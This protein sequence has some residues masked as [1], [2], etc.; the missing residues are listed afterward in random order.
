MRLTPE[1]TDLL[2]GCPCAKCGARALKV[3][4]KFHTVEADPYKLRHSLAGA[5]VKF[6]MEEWPW[7]AC[8][9]CGAECKGKI[10]TND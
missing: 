7:L 9:G 10:A 4:Y 3:I 5:Q 2:E 6:S 1:L 8:S